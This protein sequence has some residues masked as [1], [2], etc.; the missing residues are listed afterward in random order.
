MRA[1]H[2]V[3]AAAFALA[4]TA[5]PASAEVQLTLDNG[6][7][8]L[9]A[10]NAT[11]SQILAEWARVGQAHIVNGER[12]PG[13]P[14]TLELNGV[15]EAQALDVIL[16]GVGGGYVLAPRTTAVPKASSYDRIFI[17]LATTPARPPAPTPVNAQQRY[18]PP[19]SPRA[20]DPDDAPPQPLPLPPQQR[21]Q[22]QPFQGNRDGFVPAGTPT[23]GAPPS[24]GAPRGVPPS[25]GAA[26]VGVAVPGMIIP[27]TEQPGQPQV[28]QQNQQP[29]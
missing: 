7:V 20:D 23:F 22:G 19:P 18:V 1:R 27:A 17:V 10:K 25:A 29:Q 13:A 14:L 6:H 15:T 11:I 28:P 3:A 26:P 4:A 2:F 5:Q 8:T 12:V 24:V 9:S 16:R 21:P